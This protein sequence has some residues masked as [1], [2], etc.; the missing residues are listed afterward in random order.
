MTVQ[1]PVSI[2]VFS[3]LKGC[4]I[5]KF[6]LRGRVIWTPVFIIAIF[7]VPGSI[8]GRVVENSLLYNVSGLSICGTSLLFHN[9][10]AL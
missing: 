4:I 6:D 9:T 8:F 5:S 10:S 1:I 3:R 7:E 2:L